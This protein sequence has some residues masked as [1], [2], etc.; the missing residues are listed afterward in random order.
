MAR[1]MT[2]KN[3]A[4]I[5][6]CWLISV[7][8]WGDLT[9]VTVSP[10]QSHHLAD[11]DLELTLTWTVHSDPNHSTGA[12]SDNGVITS[13]ITGQTL[14]QFGQRLSEPNRESLTFSET[15]TLS[16]E[17]MQTW[18]NQGIDQLEL[19]R[20]F[21]A[22]RSASVTAR[23]TLSLSSNQ[24]SLKRQLSQSLAFEALSLIMPNDSAINAQTLVPLKAKLQMTYVGQGQLRGQ[25]Q[26]NGPIGND[27]SG[28]FRN[29]DSVNQWLTSF[30]RATL[31]SPKLP[32]TQ[33]GNYVVRFCLA[34]SE[35]STD[36]SALSPT[37]SYRVNANQA[38]Q[39]IIK[40]IQ[41]SLSLAPTSTPF[42]WQPV[43]NAS[44]YQLEFFD[45]NLTPNFVTGIWVK[46][47][48]SQTQLTDLMLLKLQHHQ[49]YY[50]R[51]SA[52]DKQGQWLGSS[53]SQTIQLTP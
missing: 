31:I 50:W 37:A 20:V 8:A 46:P 35:T 18:L 9:S 40:I 10:S 5:F 23:A 39:V 11:S 34:E 2:R 15:L 7:C 21:S 12:L 32:T 51:V 1:T 14:G 30:N 53:V 29:L 22:D 28:Q 13:G 49:T 16:R 19:T 44:V 26:V 6:L 25:W 48:Q 38:T 3:L 33:P 52:Y 45:T 24:L 41:P 36:C 42:Q 43:A 47:P 4:L 17:Q 27:L